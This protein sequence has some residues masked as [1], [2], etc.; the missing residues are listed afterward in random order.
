[1][2]P[3][4]P[5]VLEHLGLGP[6]SLDGALGTEL[7]RRGVP[8][9][10]RLWSTHAPLA[11]PDQVVA[12]HREYLEAGAALLTANTLRTQARGGLVGRGAA[13]CA[14]AIALAREAIRDAG[15][16]H[17]AALVAGSAPPLQDCDRPDLAPDDDALAREHGALAENLASAGADLML[18]QTDHVSPNDALA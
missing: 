18:C 7:E 13:L 1:M 12:I 10:L 11:A 17:G 14:E 5:A 16:P 15:A 6:W 3:R 4:G 2:S 8:S 9:T